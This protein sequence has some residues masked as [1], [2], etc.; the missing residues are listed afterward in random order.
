MSKRKAGFS[1]DLTELSTAAFRVP[2]PQLS[3]FE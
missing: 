1:G 2:S 3:L